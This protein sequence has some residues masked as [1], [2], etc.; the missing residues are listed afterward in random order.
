[1]DVDVNVNVNMHRI[2][3]STSTSATGRSNINSNYGNGSTTSVTLPTRRRSFLLATVEDNTSDS[4]SNN[5][6]ASPPS[7]PTPTPR[8]TR[9]IDDILYGDDRDDIDNGIDVDVDSDASNNNE[10]N[11]TTR[12]I[13]SLESSLQREKERS[14]TLAVRLAY[15]EQV[16]AEQKKRLEDKRY[17]LVSK[18]QA[19]TETTRK[20]RDL[21]KKVGGVVASGVH[22]G[23]S[24][25]N[26]NSASTST[27]TSTT[28]KR[29]K[30][31]KIPPRRPPP[32]RRPPPPTPWL[33]KQPPLT[34][35]ERQYPLLSDWSLNPN[36]G[37]LKGTV[38]SH[39]S[40]PDGT[41]IVTSG[42][43]EQSFKVAYDPNL[44]FQQGQPCTVVTTRSG[45][46]YQLGYRKRIIPAAEIAN[47][48]PTLQ[49]QTLQQQQQQ[50]QQ[51]LTFQ[52]Q[53]LQQQ[54]SPPP[55]H[56]SNLQY[57]DLEFPLT[58][59]SISNG[60]GTKYV[61]AGTPKRKP[62]GRSEIVM[63]YKCDEQK[64][65]CDTSTPV[66]VKLSTHKV[67]LER[68]YENYMKI[69]KDNNNGDNYNYDNGDNNNNKQSWGMWFGGGG[70]N[71]NDSNNNPSSSSS[72]PALLP[73]SSPSDPFVRCYDFLPV[74]EGSIKYAQHSALVLEKGHEDLRE[75]EFRL[76]VQDDPE[77][78]LPTT[79]DDTVVRD[80][81]KVAAKGLH[82]LHT[83]GRLV[84]TDLKAENLILMQPPVLDGD[85]DG[86]GD[87][88]A[89]ATIKGVDLESCIPVRGNPLDYTPEACPPEFAHFH[90]GGNPYDFVLEYS[91]DVWSF[92]MLAYELATGRPFF[93]G[94]TPQEI[95]QAL[96]DPGF[97][98]PE[99]PLQPAQTTETTTQQQQQEDNSAL[100][101]LIRSCLR[102]D[103]KRR[104]PVSKIL[105]HRYFHPEL[106]YGGAWGGRER[107]EPAGAPEQQQFLG[108]TFW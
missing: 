106:R 68:E 74:C 76:Q 101:D 44:D 26:S 37:E 80:A 3:A 95:M 38:G 53:T 90:L 42:L 78:P 33:A 34:S 83:K 51:Q 39:P 66:V 22:S 31:I 6:D 92:G 18:N 41:T 65:I 73:P 98:P 87:G 104:I 48:Q 30:T 75:Y 10:N 100:G 21:E 79:I 81:L 64:N 102:M 91:Y 67:K 15:A 99:L 63:A 20:L 86:N 94:K 58:G 107:V 55:L 70:S 82:A 88:A 69:Q 27:S 54:Q 17:S 19:L 16:I 36:T 32:T 8:R 72:T 103:P 47:L 24:N 23:V 61:L 40:I 52:Q 56:P 1:V 11:D 9:R 57:P 85:T 45:S 2:P 108:G 59:Q 60:R 46:K 71:N 50:Q 105:K 5:S 25:S 93:R 62:S 28:N 89:T 49:Q 13:S 77:Y 96:A 29:R 35:K 12:S 4:S 84:Y 97:V 7:F 43:E 14:N